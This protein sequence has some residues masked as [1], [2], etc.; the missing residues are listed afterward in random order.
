MPFAHNGDVSDAAAGLTLPLVGTAASS[1][2]RAKLALCRPRQSPP[3]KPKS[4][5]HYIRYLHLMH[6]V[7][8]ASIPLM[9]LALTKCEGQSDQGARLA[10][11]Y[12]HHIVEESGHVELILQDLKDL[13]IS[14]QEA[15]ARMPNLT[16]V[17]MTGAQYYWLEHVSPLPLL[18]YIAFLEGVPPTAVTI[19]AVKNL[20]PEGSKAYRALA[21]HAEA[22]PYHNRELDELLDR[23]ALTPQ[24]G[25][26]IGASALQTSALFLEAAI[27]II[28]E[29]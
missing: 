8:R 2:L 9:E 26:L 15:T 23:L 10:D 14:N 6:D 19:D 11:Y 24:Q 28:G 13:G 29:P 21:V 27:S 16:I 3:F 7:I 4:L 20:L 5:A 17:A 18:G 1:G 22:D 12:R 25:S